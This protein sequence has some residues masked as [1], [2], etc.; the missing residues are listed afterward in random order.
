M[1]HTSFGDVSYSLCV[2]ELV[3]WLLPP[4]GRDY[5]CLLPCSILCAAGTELKPLCMLES[6]PP[7]ELDSAC[8]G[9]DY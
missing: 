4:K 1:S 5:R 8:P 3:L 7:S 9:I 2:A 6:S